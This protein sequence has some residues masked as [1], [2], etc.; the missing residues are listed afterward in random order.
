[1]GHFC[2]NF[3]VCHVVENLPVASCCSFYDLFNSNSDY[4][5]SKIM[6][7]GE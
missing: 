2:H 1:M 6:G 4:L 7:I 5:A 3:L